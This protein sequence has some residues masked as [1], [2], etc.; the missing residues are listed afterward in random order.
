[1][2]EG[3]GGNRRMNPDAHLCYGIGN[4]QEMLCAM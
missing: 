3:S 4:V 2:P 1:M